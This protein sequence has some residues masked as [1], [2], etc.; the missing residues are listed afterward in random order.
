MS[1]IRPRP[2][3][4]PIIVEP[5]AASPQPPVGRAAGPT[6]AERPEREGPRPATRQQP[7]DMLADYR[8]QR[9]ASQ[10]HAVLQ[11]ARLIRDRC[12][13]V[14]VIA[15]AGEMLAARTLLAACCHPFHDALPRAER[16]GRPRILFS[17]GVL[18]NDR[19]Q[20]LLDLVA[21]AGR[22]SADDLLDRW[23]VVVVANSSIPVS[24]AAAARLFVDTLAAQVGGRCP[25][26]AE[27]VVTVGAPLAF[28]AESLGGHPPL[29][30]PAACAGA[31]SVFS[32]AA[33]LPAAIAGVD[34]VR[35]LEG[36]VAMNSRTSEAPRD[37]NPV[38]RFLLSDP[39]GDGPTAPTGRL[40][41]L[42]AAD[43]QL[44]PICAWFECLGEP[45][46]ADA[47]PTATI[48]VTGGEPRR[49]PLGLSSAGPWW[50]GVRGLELEGL[51]G[52]SWP[53]LARRETPAPARAEIRLPRIDEHAV[54]QLLQLLLLAA[55]ERQAGR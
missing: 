32:A 13:R 40:P 38:A 11:A 45:V 43:E 27:R 42:V 17:G 6:G 26:L 50:T 35:V 55:D 20:G 7:A 10:L 22:G 37:E 47:P 28:L 9:P 39:A 1:V 15:E 4:D 53:D 36:A 29:P 12:D 8:L 51:E 48:R 5:A 16:G 30:L 46:A 52:C 19:D 54:G 33:L 21:P 3:T 23:A 25:S 34:V 24:V 31:R 49:D 44:G 18:A 41:R 2:P 14:I